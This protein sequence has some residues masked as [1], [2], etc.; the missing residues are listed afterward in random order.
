MAF[1]EDVIPYDRFTDDLNTI[2][3][4]LDTKLFCTCVNKVEF[5]GRHT[6]ALRP[7]DMCVDSIFDGITNKLLSQNQKCLVI[8]EAQQSE[9]RELHK[10]IVSWYNS[11]PIEIQRKIAG[12]YFNKKWTNDFK[13]TYF[14]LEFADLL[15]YPIYRLFKNKERIRG[16]ETVE[17]KLFGYPD[18]VGNGLLFPK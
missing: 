6:R 10:H 8:V 3:E 13:N 4:M 11:K 12:V 15:C 16:I 14:G 9:D 17:K 18:F 2:I 7:Y 5:R 1:S